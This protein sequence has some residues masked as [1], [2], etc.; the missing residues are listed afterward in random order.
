MTDQILEI[1]SYFFIFTGAFLM[2]TGT[3]GVIRF[4]DFYTRLHPAGISDSL[5]APMVLT[6][7][8]INTPFEMATTKVLLIIIF[9][10]ITGTTATHALAKSAHQSGLKPITEKD[11]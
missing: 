3:I 6:G 2:T 4:P 8:A 7:I 5:G 9:M 1:I 11:D 10:W